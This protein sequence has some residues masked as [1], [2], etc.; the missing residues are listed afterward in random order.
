MF[1][2]ISEKVKK[3]RIYVIGKNLDG[4]QKFAG[5]GPGTFY[6]MVL[7]NFAPK[8]EKKREKT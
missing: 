1:F 2:Y 5:R 6:L 3:Q 7:E 8:S 4:A